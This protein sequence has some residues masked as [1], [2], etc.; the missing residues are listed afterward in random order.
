MGIRY[1]KAKEWSA[2]FCFPNCIT[3][4][5][6]QIQFVSEPIL[7]KSNSFLSQDSERCFFHLSLL[8]IFKMIMAEGGEKGGGICSLLELTRFLPQ[9]L[10]FATPATFP[11]GVLF[12]FNLFACFVWSLGKEWNGLDLSGRLG[13]ASHLAQENAITARSPKQSPYFPLDIFCFMVVVVIVAGGIIL[14]SRHECYV[15]TAHANFDGIELVLA[16]LFTWLMP[17][18]KR[19]QKTP[20]SGIADCR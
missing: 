14:A 1:V 4:G 18:N 12:V 17:I 7:L 5:S 9:L 10:S 8:F 6:S 20:E 11:C 2:T 19:R 16:F 13:P 3:R 15:G